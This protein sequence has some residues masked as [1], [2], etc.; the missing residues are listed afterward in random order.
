M[1]LGLLAVSA[2]YTWRFTVW[3][4]QAGGYWS[5][6]TGRHPHP[7][8]PMASSA[9]AAVSAASANQASQASKGSK[10]SPALSLFWMILTPTP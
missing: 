3:A 8:D 1:M 5:L 9:S 10:A 4:A 7:T 6:L 2:F